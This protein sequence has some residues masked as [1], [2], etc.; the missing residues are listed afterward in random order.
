VILDR[1]GPG[2]AALAA[3]EKLDAVF[4][5][6]FS[7]GTNIT[8]QLAFVDLKN[9]TTTRSTR[10]EPG[11]VLGVARTDLGAPL[12]NQTD[13]HV[14]KTLAGNVSL[15]L[16]AA[17]EGFIQGG[18][19]YTA[20]IAFTNGSR[21]IGSTTID[22]KP[23]NEAISATFGAS[24]QALP[25]AADPTSRVPG[26]VT[27]VVFSLTNETLPA[28]GDGQTARLSTSWWAALSA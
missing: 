1:V 3:D 2:P 7:L 10:F 9:M 26:E 28:P 18:S 17:D 20:T 16:Y 21:F 5:V 4:D 24:N 22:A 27:S 25:A 11:S 23:G 6:S 8:R 19:T 13:G 15:V 12:I 14:D